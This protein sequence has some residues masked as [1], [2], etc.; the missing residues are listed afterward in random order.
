M[1]CKKKKV[2]I[3][4]TNITIDNANYNIN[5]KNNKVVQGPEIVTTGLGFFTDN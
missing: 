5:N 1:S 3:D 4:T 2:N